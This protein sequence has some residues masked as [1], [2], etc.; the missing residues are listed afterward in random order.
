MHLN[1]KDIESILSGY[2]DKYITKYI[3]DYAFYEQDN[4]DKTIKE[5]IVHPKVKLRYR[6][7]GNDFKNWYHMLYLKNY[8]QA[9]S[10]NR[11]AFSDLCGLYTYPEIFRFKYDLKQIGRVVYRPNKKRREELEDNG[12]EIVE[13][14]GEYYIKK[15]VYY[16]EKNL[17]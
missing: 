10:Q 7:Y 2:F 6:V 16:F 17:T 13:I 1:R 4:Y 14:A 3:V 5:M 8:K 11:W 9:I 12:D 15:V